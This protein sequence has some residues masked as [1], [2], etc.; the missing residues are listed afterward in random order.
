MAGNYTR[1]FTTHLDE[2]VYTF[3]LPAG[4][5]QEGLK[6]RV[7]SRLVPD[8][9]HEVRL[10]GQPGMVY[11][12]PGTFTMGSPL[13]EAERQQFGGDETQHSVTLTRGFWMGK[14]E[15]TQGEYLEVMGNNPSYFRNGRAPYSGGNGGAVRN[16]LRHPVDTVSWIDATNYCGK[17]TARE[18]GAGRIPAGWGYRLPTE[19]EWEYACRAGTTSAF[20]YGMALRQGMAN[21]WTLYEYDSTVGTINTSKTPLG[22]TSD[23]GSYGSNAYG[24]YDMHGNVWEWCQDWYGTYPVN[25]SDPVGPTTGSNRVIRGGGW[26]SYGEG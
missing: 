13:S 8:I 15:V 11:I 20:H 26:F 4:A 1:V 14:Y 21:F 23:V 6:L 18:L 22:R 17:L 12:P 19:G 5:T 24:L 7:S 3:T 10:C 9:A 25:V 2:A 16:E